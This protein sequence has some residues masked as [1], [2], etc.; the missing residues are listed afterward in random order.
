MRI[1]ELTP[2]T[3]ITFLIIISGQQLAFNSKIQ[4]VYPKKHLVLAE[5][6]YHEG[7]IVSFH[8]KNVIVNLLVESADDKP[9]LFKNITVTTMKKPDGSLCYSLATVAESKPY[10]RRECYRCYVGVPSS[11]QG[12]SNRA[13]Y[14]AIIRDVSVSGFSVTCDEYLG[15]EPNQTV[16]VVLNDYIGELAENF[17][18]HLYGLIVRI[19]EFED[20][21]VLYGCRFNNFVAGLE[22]YIMK[23]ERIRLRNSNGGKL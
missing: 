6:I 15:L 22:N 9:Q 23:K 14:D 5:P 11:I 10:N 8:G 20:G 17:S 21:K 4:E 12:G 3:T 1:Q 2:G 13:A 16:H 7:K 19:Q 18:F